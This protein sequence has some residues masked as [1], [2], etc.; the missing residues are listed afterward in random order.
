VCLNPSSSVVVGRKV[1]RN[2]VNLDLDTR[3]TAQYWHWKWRQTGCCVYFVSW[4][5]ICYQL[6]CSALKKRPKTSLLTRIAVLLT[7][8][9]LF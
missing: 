9:V 2:S 1:S 5:A 3:R 6:L 4:S 8:R 7:K